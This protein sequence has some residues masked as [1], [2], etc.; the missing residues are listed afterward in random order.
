[1][2]VRLSSRI[3]MGLE[4]TTFFKNICVAS[5]QFGIDNSS[6]TKNLE[7]KNKTIRRKR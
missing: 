3:G 2:F 6:L 1:M 4:G 5:K 7:I